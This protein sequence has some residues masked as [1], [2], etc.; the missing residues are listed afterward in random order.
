MGK[1][2]EEREDSYTHND[3]QIMLEESRNVMKKHS[4]LDVWMKVTLSFFSYVLVIFIVSICIQYFSLMS[5]PRSP[6][7]SSPPPPR[8]LTFLQSFLSGGLAACVAECCSIPFDTAKVRMQLQ[9]GNVQSVAAQ[10]QYRNLGHALGRIAAEEGPLALFKGLVPGLQR[11]MVFA[12]IR[13]G[14][15]QPVRDYYHRGPGE[16]PLIKKI[17]AGLTTGA[18]GITVANPTDVV[19]IR[20][21]AEGRLPPGVPRQYSGSLDAYQ[22][23][24]ATDGISGLWRGYIPNLIRNSTIC[25]AELASYDQIKQSILSSKLMPDGV[26]AHLVSGLGAGFIATVIGSP[27]DVLKTRVMNTKDGKPIFNGIVDCLSK[28]IKN[29]GFG[30][31]YK[32][33]WANFVRIGRCVFHF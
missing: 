18:I 22:K 15:Y 5:G 6:S 30:A 11:Q 9:S 32:G 12:G 26:P 4:V 27:V 24:L 16:P 19:K 2:E 17:L 29:E 21:Q 14:L 7:S 8:P 10:V 20:L 13:I 33:F 25:A 1:E 28:T 3:R 31:F 23:I